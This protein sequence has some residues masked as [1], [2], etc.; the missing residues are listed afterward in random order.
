MDQSKIDALRVQPVAT[1]SHLI[2]GKY[3]PSSDGGTMEILSPIDGQTLTH[4][5]RGTPADMEAAIASARAAF[6]DR[7]W[8]GQSPAAR[9][10]VLMKWD[11]LIEANAL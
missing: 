2:D 6:E 11:D 8:A 4:V 5:A 10:K 1:F 9:K 3:V 7:R